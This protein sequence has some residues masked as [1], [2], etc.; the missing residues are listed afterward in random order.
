[1][2]SMATAPTSALVVSGARRQ[3]DAR[4]VLI[5]GLKT[6]RGT[7][8][9]KPVRGTK[10]AAAATKKPT[11]PA[12]KAVKPTPKK[13][14]KVPDKKA[15]K[16]TLAAL[17]KEKELAKKSKPVAKPPAKVEKKAEEKKEEPAPQVAAHEPAQ[18]IKEL[19]EEKPQEVAGDPL[20]TQEVIYVGRDDLRE[21]QTQS[22]VADALQKHW[23]SPSGIAPDTCC[24]I[25]F[26]IDAEGKACNVTMKQQSKVLIFDVAARTAII[27]AHFSPAA[28]GKQFTVA[29]KP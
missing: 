5:P 12:K 19:I 23:Q 22:V 28:Q 7:E 16:T 24:F 3:T 11:P 26:D 14:T 9:D 1:M 6:V 27:Q 2:G 15:Q 25:T 18:E 21:I 17:P 13:V 8:F 20:A 29:F 10:F 4:M